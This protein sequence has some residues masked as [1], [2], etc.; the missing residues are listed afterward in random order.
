MTGFDE[1]PLEVRRLHWG[2]FDGTCTC[3]DPHA[4]PPGRSY[5]DEALEV[6]ARL[7]GT[8]RVM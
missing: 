6:W 2:W 3:H 5:R 1:L 7:T 4:T 8:A